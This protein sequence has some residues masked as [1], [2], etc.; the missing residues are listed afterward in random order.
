MLDRR[1]TLRLGALSAAMSLPLPSLA[2][3][4]F[5]ARDVRIVVPFPAGGVTDIFARLIA[6]RLATGWGRTVAVEN[7]PGGNALTGADAVAKGEA[8]GH[9]VLAATL[10]HAVNATLFPNAPYDLLRDLTPVT[11]LGSLPLVVVVPAS[12]PATSLAH[13]AEQARSRPLR[14]A[15][16]GNG[17]PPHLAL[18]VLRRGGGAA[19][20]FTH[21]PFAGG[22]PATAALLA[23]EVD[24]MAGN[25]P[26]VLE[27]VRAGRLRALALCAEARH[28]LL[29]DVPTSAEAGMPDLVLG[30]WVAFLVPAATPASARAALEA[31][32]LAAL[33]DQAVA[34]QA[35]DRGFEVLAWDAARSRRHVEAEVAR[36]AAVIREAGIRAG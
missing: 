7:R 20:Q 23:G 15:S 36:W 34:Q 18:E 14:V 35:E 32:S 30:N 29:P 4:A 16:A 21:V 22:A 33:R 25:L 31:A 28:R 27:H 3:P 17:T 2:Q 24:V 8:D 6:S 9:L 12:S 11:V 1:S 5:P 10:A 13:L 26:E 19:A